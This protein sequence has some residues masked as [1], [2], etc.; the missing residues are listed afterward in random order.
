MSFPTKMQV[1][2]AVNNHSSQDLSAPHVT[3]A[4]FMQLNVSKCMELVPG[5]SVTIKHDLFSRLEPLVLPTFGLAE[6]RNKAFFVPMRT[7]WPAW[8]DFDNDTI[9]VFDEGEGIPAN[10]PLVS[11]RVFYDF[12][13]SSDCAVRLSQD[14]EN[15]SRSFVAIEEGGGRWPYRFTPFGRYCY[16]ILRS[17]GYGPIMDYRLN[18]FDSVLPL[19]GLCKI[20]LDWFFPSQYSASGLFASVQRLLTQNVMVGSSLSFISKYDLLDI[21]VMLQFVAYDPDYFT[22]AWDNPISP[23]EGAFSD[24]HIFDITNDA[25]E[26][27][28][29]NTF[30][31]NGTPFVINSENDGPTVLTQYS[32]DA[33]KAMTDYTK[34]N[35]ISS[36]N[37]DRHFARYG[38]RLASEKLNRSI[39]LHEYRQPVQFGDVTSMANTEGAS[40]GD[41][42]GKGISYGENT[43]TFQSD[44]EFGY[45]FVVTTI[46]P[47]TYYYQGVNRHVKHLTKTDF[48]KPEYDALGTQAISQTEYYSPLTQPLQDSDNINPEN[49]YGFTSRYAEYK[50]PHALI[51]GDYVDDAI[52]SGKGAWTLFR[53]VSN[54]THGYYHSFMQIVG[55][56]A[57][58]YNRIF[59]YV[60]SDVD[61]FNIIHHFDIKSS[62]PGKSLFDTYDFKDEDKSQKVSIDVGGTTVS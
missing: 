53:D 20:Y 12:L 9:R 40:L 54:S 24:F 36:R 28:V 50:V 3:T 22:S 7:I 13:T 58:Q 14:D 29:T 30:G 45:L 48:F 21:F 19:F 26:S 4:S 55:S 42:A 34:R 5:Q 41:Y 60:G 43:F 27:Q 51:S 56:D 52:N 59:Q 44:G 15:Q 62:F 49:V 1:P 23:N 16:K 8:N 25:T 11:N 39:L 61:H 57:E 35:Q 47:K 37:L 31:G 46:I 6:I 17:L 2:V 18:S 38:Y 32:L 33:L 10:V